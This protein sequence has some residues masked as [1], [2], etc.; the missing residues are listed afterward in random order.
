M[1]TSRGAER[2]T[3]NSGGPVSREPRLE[4]IHLMLRFG[5]HDSA[6]CERV[7]RKRLPLNGEAA[8]RIDVA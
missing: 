8:P 2:F 4:E 3:I 1:R 7:T 6:G 5:W